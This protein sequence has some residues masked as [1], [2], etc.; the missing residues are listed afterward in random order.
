[1][2]LIEWYTVWLDGIRWK[3]MDGVQLKN[4]SSIMEVVLADKSPLLHHTP[5]SF[6]AITF[7]GQSKFFFIDVQYE[8][9]SSI[10]IRRTIQSF[11]HLSTV[12]TGDIAAMLVVV[13][14]K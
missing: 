12:G 3:E 4:S 7:H 10:N 9:M 13:E 6:H 5:T 11:S 14:C 2:G 1:M 8:F